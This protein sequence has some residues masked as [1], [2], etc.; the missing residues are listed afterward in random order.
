LIGIAD[1]RFT[2][3]SDRT[4]K[5]RLG[6]TV[7]DSLRKRSIRTLDPK[8][9]SGAVPP[10]RHGGRI[11]RQALPIERVE[12]SRLNGTRTSKPSERCELIQTV[13]HSRQGAYRLHNRIS[14]KKANDQ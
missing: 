13:L 11:D 6:S 12:A 14:T 8:H 7:T 1:D 5:Y 3:E 4:T 10:S 2:I 9:A